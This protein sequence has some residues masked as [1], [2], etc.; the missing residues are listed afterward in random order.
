MCSDRLVDEGMTL[1]T[2]HNLWGY[3]TLA[4]PNAKGVRH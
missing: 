3:I 2:F 4:T 1:K